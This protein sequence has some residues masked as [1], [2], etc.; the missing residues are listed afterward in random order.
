MAKVAI[1]GGGPAGSATALNLLREGVDPHDITIFDRAVFPRPKLCGGALTWRGTDALRTLVGDQPELGG[2]TR[3]LEFR[4]SL[5]AFPVQERGAQWLYD[6]AHLDHLL[7]TRCIDAGVQVHQGTTVKSVQVD[8][9]RAAVVTKSGL[10]TYDWVVGADGAR[11]VVARSLGFQ[12]GIVGRLVEAVYR[13]SAGSRHERDRL[14]FDFDPIIDGIPGYAW[15]FAYPKPHT[16]DLWRSGERSGGGAE[17]VDSQAPKAP[18]IERSR[19]AKGSIN[20]ARVEA[21]RTR[22]CGARGTRARRR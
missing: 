16:A 8:G 1:V 9:D 7:L 12:G 20:K 15:I 10:E 13:A 17:A 3:S 11:G 6:R 4:C 5:G 2:E 14:Y 21:R 18:R 22:A 19:G